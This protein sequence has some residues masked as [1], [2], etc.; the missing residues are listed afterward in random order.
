MKPILHFMP[1]CSVDLY[2]SLLALISVEVGSVPDYGWAS[3]SH[4]ACVMI[5][6]FPLAAVSMNKVNIFCSEMTAI[7]HSMTQRA[8]NL[9][10]SVF[11]WRFYHLKVMSPLFSVFCLC[12][13]VIIFTEVEDIMKSPHSACKNRCANASERGV[14]CRM[15][16]MKYWEHHCVVAIIDVLFCFCCACLRGFQKEWLTIWGIT[17]QPNTWLPDLKWR[18]CFPVMSGSFASATNK[19]Q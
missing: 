2:Q 6:L 9:F 10:K 15:L 1:V 11:F 4:S 5:S 16:T 18:A 17:L 7:H 12:T 3:E 8:C 19:L 14:E 13:F